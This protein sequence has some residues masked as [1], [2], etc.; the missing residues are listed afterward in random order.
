MLSKM[1][2]S[3][4]CLL[5]LAGIL[6]AMGTA[7]QSA[8]GAVSSVICNTDNAFIKNCTTILPEKRTCGIIALFS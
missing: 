5:Q 1:R 8:C 6:N 7:G 3:N 4:S 2:T